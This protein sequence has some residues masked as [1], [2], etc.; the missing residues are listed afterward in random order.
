MD[1]T[2]NIKTVVNK[3]GTI[4]TEFRTFPMEVIAG[5]ANFDVELKE[6]GARFKFNFAEVY[7]NSRLGK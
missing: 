4:A 5:E 3:V 7:W 1:K 2:P 6:S